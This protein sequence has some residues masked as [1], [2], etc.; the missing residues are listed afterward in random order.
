M[1]RSVKKGVG[2]GLTSGVI[3]TLGLLIGLNASTHSRV[4]IISGILVI[5]VA[6]SLSDALGIHAS[7]ET[8]KNHSHGEI[9]MSTVSTFLS[10]GVFSLS[11]VLPILLLPLSQ[12]IIA[13]II[14]GLTLIIILNYHLAKIRKTN[15]STSLI[16]HVVIAIIV[17]ILSH[18]IGSY[19]RNY[20]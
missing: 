20:L 8:E 6:D 11:F 18:L 5:A 4:V 15:I 17:I 7:E 3:T 14:W 10:K 13:S 16:E 19:I 9:W 2:F 1:K 12:A